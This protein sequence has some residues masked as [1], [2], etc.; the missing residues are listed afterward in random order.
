MVDGSGLRTAR[1]IIFGNVALSYEFIKFYL[2]ET[3]VKFTFISLKPSQGRKERKE[4]K[5]KK[6]EEEG[7]WQE[8][9]ADYHI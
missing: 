3:T 2:E 8:T 9:M 6:E 4:G 7:G 5:K 1:A